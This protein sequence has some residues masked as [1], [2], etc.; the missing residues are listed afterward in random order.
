ML[1]NVRF[2]KKGSYDEVRI[3]K[4]KKAKEGVKLIDIRWNYNIHISLKEEVENASIVL[5]HLLSTGELVL[6]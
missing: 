2:E 1:K 6:F 5:M 3:G 4:V